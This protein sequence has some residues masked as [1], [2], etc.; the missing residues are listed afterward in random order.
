MSLLLTRGRFQETLL[1][2]RSSPPES[3]PFALLMLNPDEARTHFFRCADS[4]RCKDAQEPI[5]GLDYPHEE[6]RLVGVTLGELE[7]IAAKKLGTPRQS[8][9]AKYRRDFRT[10]ATTCGV[11][12]LSVLLGWMVGRAGWNAAV[13]RGEKPVPTVPEEVLAATAPVSHLQTLA[14]RS[15]QPIELAKPAPSPPVSAT[16]GGV[17]F[18]SPSDARSFFTQGEVTQVEGTK[19]SNA[20]DAIDTGLYSASDGYV[21]DKV[22][23]KYPESAKQERIQGP[24]VLSALVGTDGL[25]R[26]LKVLRGNP[27]LVQAAADAVRQWRFQPHLL[28]GQPTEFET[29]ITVNFSLS[30]RRCPTKSP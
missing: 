27:Q 5:V 6:S 17:I 19:K 22:L 15:E 23:P 10:A 16:P 13:E 7:P 4:E 28:K 11:V 21:L 8:H 26:E 24:V 2:V 18:R 29:R 12:T 30:C 1:A 20:P 25:V 3:P 9:R 14:P